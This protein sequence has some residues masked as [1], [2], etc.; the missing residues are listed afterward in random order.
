[1]W[2][3]IDRFRPVHLQG[4]VQSLL[5]GQIRKIEPVLKEVDAHHPFHTDR[6]AS[7]TLRLWIERLDGFGQL[8]GE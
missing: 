7:H 1:M 8:L 4:V 5:G 2:G 3:G 6:L